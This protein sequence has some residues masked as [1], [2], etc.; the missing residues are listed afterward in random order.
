TGEGFYL[1]ASGIELHLDKKEYRVGDEA[2]ILIVPPLSKKFP[3]LFAVEGQKIF[4]YQLLEGSEGPQEVTVPVTK[5][6]VM[7]G[8]LSVTTFFDGNYYNESL[9]LPIVPEN[10]LKIEITTD[11]EV[12]RPGEKGKVTVKVTG[13]DQKPRQCDLSLAV[14]DQA[15]FDI[16]NEWLEDIYH[17]FYQ[18]FYNRV[19]TQSSTY[20]YFY[21]QGEVVGNIKPQMKEGDGK[22][23]GGEPVLRKYFPDTMLWLPNVQTDINGIYQGEF[24]CPDN[25][26]TWRVEVKAENVQ[27]FGETV[28]T[29]KTSLPFAIRIEMPP[30]LTQGD[31]LKTQ[32][33]LWNEHVSQKVGIEAKSSPEL[34]LGTYPREVIVKEKENLVFPLE[35]TAQKDG[36]SQLQIYARGES[37]NDALEVSQP[38]FPQGVTVEQYTSVFATNGKAVLDFPVY[39]EQFSH[40]PAVEIQIFRNIESTI[41]RVMEDMYWYP[42]GCTEQTSS[43]MISLLA[44]PVN[45]TT[46]WVNDIPRVIREGIYQLYSLQHYDGGWGWWESD[47]SKVFNTAHALFALLVAR[48]NG[49]PVSDA[50]I[51][52]GKRY[53]SENLARESAQ[54]QA[55]ARVVLSRYGEKLPP[56][57]PQDFA[58]G[59]KEVEDSTI[60]L[61]SMVTTGNLQQKIQQELVLRAQPAGDTVFFGHS[62][63]EKYWE[64]TRFLDTCFAAWALKDINREMAGKAFLWLL[65]TV[66][67]D[68]YTSTLEKAYFLNLAPAFVEKPATDTGDFSVRLNER[69]LAQGQM[70]PKEN[71]KT[72][73]LSPDQTQKGTN[74]LEVQGS[75]VYCATAL[76]KGFSRT[77]LLSETL[78]V[79]KTYWKLK[80]VPLEDGTFV[81]AR[82][83]ITVL[84]PGDEVVCEIL[85]TSPVELDNL[86][87]EDGL[88]AGFEFIRGDSAYRLQNVKEEEQI[89]PEKKIQ[90]GQP[91]IFVYHIRAG[92]NVIRYYLR[93]R[94]TGTF[95]VRPAKAYLMYFPEVRGYSKENVFQSGR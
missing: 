24:L 58:K 8:Y 15:I 17:H 37:D 35:V 75:G 76:V 90:N 52:N 29:F 81:F 64:D 95:Y 45:E 54:D 42:Y 41:F 38:V 71:S 62:T 1:P 12:Y 92:E 77:N 39:P 78:A 26:S 60:A 2:K 63:P 14:V 51:E 32:V 7:G 89:F 13:K 43:R 85:V 87:I 88:P 66:Q 44:L 82:E 84:V 65:R 28:N 34:L 86:V 56:I 22:G 83:P 40:V 11:K 69:V 48:K 4:R 80:P 74:H 49:Y 3:S 33:T 91:V 30:F 21:G 73:T 9:E 57:N 55:F 61:L 25:L 16:S 70:D 50:T 67:S 23:G 27:E 6:L 94:D 68:Q 79:G 19:S 72:I 5:D 10:E 31:F 53:L 47:D 93:V 18:N 46:N 36:L 20:E 59:W